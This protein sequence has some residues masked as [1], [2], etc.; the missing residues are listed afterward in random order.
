MLER[1]IFGYRRM[2][3]ETEVQYAVKEI[4]WVVLLHD[5]E[6]GLRTCQR[7]KSLSRFTPLVRIIMSRGGLPLSAVPR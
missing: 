3:G 1:N 2:S 5:V 6:E 7:R 4:T